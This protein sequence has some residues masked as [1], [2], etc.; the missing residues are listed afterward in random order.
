MVIRTN[1]GNRNRR[2]VNGAFPG[3]APPV[4]GYTTPRKKKTDSAP[5]PCEK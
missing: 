2:V 4:Y 1:R 3:W 5:P